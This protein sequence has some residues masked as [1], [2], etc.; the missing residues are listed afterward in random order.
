[1][2]LKTLTTQVAHL[3][4]SVGRFIGEEVNKISKEDIHEKGLH[5]VVTYVD[6]ESEKRLINELK[7]ILPSAGFIAEEDPKLK[8]AER[9]NWIIDPLDG[10]TNFIHGI[11]V[12]CISVA[13]AEY[14]EII[15]GVVYEVNRDECFYAWKNG[16]A[17]LNGKNV[18]VSAVSDL[19]DSLLAT[20]F[21][22]YDYSLM[23]P[24]LQLFE[25]LMKTTHG[26]RRLGS[27][28][29][30]LA[31]VACGRFEVFYEYGLHP[32]DVAAGVLLVKEAGG[33][34]SDFKG[35]N[36]FI[37]GRQIIAS[38]ASVFDDFLNKLKLFFASYL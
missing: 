11:P 5:D 34:V 33:I 17:F 36:D 7:K 8:K 10:T 6:K 32:W 14:G 28:A 24:Y 15:S 16:G 22:Y 1:M 9:F 25:D 18:H 38:N 21:P 12:Y 30:D 2:N 3:S 23:V 37:F 26:L 29:A 20:G 13:L 19:N 27:A 4:K 31:Y 35:G